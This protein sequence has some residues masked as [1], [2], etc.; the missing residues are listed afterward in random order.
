MR[1]KAIVR[2]SGL[3]FLYKVIS[4]R[5]GTSVVRA[6]TDEKKAHIKFTHTA[7]PA[8]AESVE[9]IAALVMISEASYKYR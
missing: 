5:V 8:H 1:Y 3:I 6:Y 9:R 7:R 4:Q 2:G